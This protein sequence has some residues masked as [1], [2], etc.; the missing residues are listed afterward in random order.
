MCEKC[1]IFFSSLFEKH[2]QHQCP[3]KQ[4]ESRL[5]N[6]VIKLKK[7]TKEEMQFTLTTKPLYS[8]IPSACRVGNYDKKKL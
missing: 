6:K 5:Y 2:L 8:S 7:K 3:S 1:T 4:I